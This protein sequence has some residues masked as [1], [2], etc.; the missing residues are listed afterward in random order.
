MPND[1]TAYEKPINIEIIEITIKDSSD[2]NLNH[3]S[4]AFG[5]K[6]ESEMN[7]LSDEDQKLLRLL[8]D[9]TSM[10][11]TPKSNNEPFRAL[12]QMADGRRSAIP[13][14][15]SSED[16]NSL[17]KI[18]DKIQ[19]TP[20][21]ARIG[22]LLWVC[23][24]PKDPAH[25]KAAI[26]CY[27]SDG[28][29]PITWPRTG[30][31]EFER[32]YRLA[33][34]LNDPGRLTKIERHLMDAL[35]NDAEDFID[36]SYL[37]GDLIGEIGALYEHTSDIA[38]RLEILGQ[39]FMSSGNYQNAIRYFGLSSKNYQKALNES[40]Y[41]SALVKTADCYAL[42]AEIHFSSS[43]GTK[44]IS[45]SMLE[46]AIHAYRRVPN[47]HRKQY[48][49]DQKISDLRHKLN[50]AGKYT[51][52]KM[53]T[54]QTPIDGADEIIAL[55]KKHVSGKTTEYEALIYLSGLCIAPNYNSLK[56]REKEN[57]SKYLFSS[58]FGSAQYSSDGRVVA[59]TPAIGFN[60]DHE[61]VDNAINDKMIR[62]FSNEIELNVKLC[63]IPALQQIL[64]EHNINKHF[65]FDMCDFSP[66]IPKS[67]INLVTSAIWLGFEYDFSTAIHLIAP[68]IEK[69][70]R[71]Q[72]KQHGVHTTHIDA[73]SIEH[74]NG[75]STLLDMH[76][77]VAIFGQDQL[78]ELKALFSDSTGPNLRN[79]VA[80][81][82]LTDSAAYSTAPVYAWW[83]LLRMIIHSI[84]TSSEKT[85]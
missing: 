58:L 44:L 68:Q 3:L 82:L 33:K 69:I 27:I 70:V 71:E 54:F 76:E 79:E 47:K 37:V 46:S 85:V 62:S 78:F 40:K 24:K 75:L 1:K 60:D 63:I 20:L 13:S 35:I 31:T 64:A 74:E 28:I 83:V 18:I 65:I 56:K 19:H 12:I 23:N 6:A 67:N 77:T 50:E 36:I 48:S 11:L 84:I 26:D 8:K 4:S 53:R 41:I 21:K 66:L 61:S 52:E 42:D 81:G 39:R 57:M 45:N 38:E 7:D 25:A 51:L 43:K 15:L 80:H 73:N 32:A 10:M 22:D 34:L 72:L 16:L 17:A 5:R 30:K 49:V 9:V 2:K 29:N 59:K 14:D 55:S